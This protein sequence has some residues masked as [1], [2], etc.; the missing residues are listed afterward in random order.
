MMP[1]SETVTLGDLIS[2]IY[3]EFL[4]LYGDED[5]ASVAAAATINEILANR[6]RNEHCGEAAA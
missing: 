1:H 5:L 2:L 6:A 3:E 4:A